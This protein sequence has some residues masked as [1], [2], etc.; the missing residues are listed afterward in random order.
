MATI[1]GFNQ[2][3]KTVIAKS[4]KSFK[5]KVKNFVD[6]VNNLK[7]KL[8]KV[9]QR[10]L[11]NR[12]INDGK[13][14]FPHKRTGN[15]MRNLIDIR[16]DTYRPNNYKRKGNLISYTHKTSNILDGGDEG[17][18]VFRIYKGKRYKYAEILQNSDKFSKW[19]RYFERLQAI[20]EKQYRS[21]IS[22]ILNKI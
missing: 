6:S 8:L 17:T 15:L 10:K 9:Q 18:T 5:V 22:R 13:T 2:L 11:M 20:F 4:E 21:S 19:N 3:R 12:S 1:K 16:V 7:S 14:D